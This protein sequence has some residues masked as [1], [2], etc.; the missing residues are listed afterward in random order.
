MGGV[1]GTRLISAPT[2]PTKCTDPDSVPGPE[3]VVSSPGWGTSASH[4]PRV[5]REDEEGSEDEEEEFRPSLCQDL[6]KLTA[7]DSD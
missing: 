7:R 6:W 1:T 4:Y 2:W 3:D 5:A